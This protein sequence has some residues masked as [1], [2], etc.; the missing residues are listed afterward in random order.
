MS[1]DNSPNSVHDAQHWSQLE[2]KGTYWGIRLL[3]GIYRWL[4]RVALMPVLYPVVFYFFLFGK[5]ARQSSLLYLQRVFAFRASEGARQPTQQPTKISHWQSFRHFMMFAQSILDKI[6]SWAGK[7][8]YESVDFPSRDALVTAVA[9]GRGGIIM[10]AHMGSIE[11]ARAVS[12]EMGDF[13]LNVL[14]H[15]A[16]AANFNKVLQKI[17]PDSQTSLMQVTKIG[18]DTAI[19]LKQKIEAGEFIAILGDRTPINSLDRNIWLPFLGKPAPFPQGPY[20]LAAVL[21]C[22][23]YMLSCL[24]AGKGFDVYFDKLAE[25]VRLPRKTRQ[26][27]IAEYAQL[28]VD[29]LAGYACQYP[30]QWFNFFDFW[31]E[32]E[33]QTE[34]SHER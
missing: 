11:V 22:P 3:F 9:S 32:F 12:A 18:P 31:H 30:Y 10:G 6:G 26:Q 34:Q 21:N 14:V 29:K 2:E 19:V 5:E 13:K 15:T 1:S 27:A 20:I 28:Y 16:N 17:N 7:I 4:G 25:R 33:H 24:H 23:L 8:S